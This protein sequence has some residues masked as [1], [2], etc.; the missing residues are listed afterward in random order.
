MLTSQQNSL[1]GQK[2]QKSSDIF[3]GGYLMK[4]KLIASILTCMMCVSMISGCQNSAADENTGSNTTA[5]GGAE[6]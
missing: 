1:A 5:A 4:R 2:S 6:E 3:T